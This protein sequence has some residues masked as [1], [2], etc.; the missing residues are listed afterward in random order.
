MFSKI[1]TNLCMTRMETNRKIR[2]LE[3]LTC[4]RTGEITEYLLSCAYWGSFTTNADLLK[5]EK[6]F[7]EAKANHVLEQLYKLF[8]NCIA[9]EEYTPFRY[10]FYKAYRYTFDSSF[11]NAAQ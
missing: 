5:Q 8:P 1:L 7:S 9:R 2:A 6:N 4:G 10:P 11:Y 3:G